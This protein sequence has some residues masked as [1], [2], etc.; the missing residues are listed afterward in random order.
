MPSDG[1]HKEGALKAVT[2]DGVLLPARHTLALVSGAN[3]AITAVD[4]PANDQ[5][6]VTISGGASYAAPAFLAFAITGQATE[7]EVGASVPVGSTTFTWSTSNPINVAANSI[8]IADTTAGTTLDSGHADDG[9]DVI[10]IGAVTLTAPGSQVWTITGMNS[11]AG[12]FSRTFTVSWLWRVYAG[13]SSNGTLTANQIKAL[14]D[15]DS[16]QAAFA[17]TYSLSAGNYKYFASPDSLGSPTQFYD[18]TNHFLISMATVADDPAYSHAAGGYSYALVS[19]TNANGV[20][21]N[22]RLYRSQ[23]PLGGSLTMQVS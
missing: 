4:D 19:V 3:V 15:S 23:Y 1:W 20:A 18:P 7:L 2:V 11:H 13:T 16:L 6:I 12:T 5:V 8:S 10:T 21:T 22:Y 9:S 17:G 14:S